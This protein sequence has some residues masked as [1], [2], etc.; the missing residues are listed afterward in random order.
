M[1]GKSGKFIKFVELFEFISV[2]NEV[3]VFVFEVNFI[4]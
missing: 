2:V 4:K 3:E 1:G